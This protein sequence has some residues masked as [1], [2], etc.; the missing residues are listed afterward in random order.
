MKT[1]SFCIEIWFILATYR[2]NTKY[3][4]TKCDTRVV[5]VRLKQAVLVRAFAFPL[6][7]LQAPTWNYQS[8]HACNLRSFVAYLM[9]QKRNCLLRWAF[10][11]PHPCLK[12]LVV[13][14][15]VLLWSLHN[16]SF[17]LPVCL[18]VCLHCLQQFFCFVFLFECEVPFIAYR[19]ACGWSERKSHTF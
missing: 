13:G 8:F 6:L 18:S 1:T 5:K 10:H 12:Y 19:T 9:W 7:V 17:S 3:E 11:V 15:M 4:E 14:E 16:L 2:T